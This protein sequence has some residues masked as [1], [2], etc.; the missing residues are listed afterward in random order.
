MLYKYFPSGTVKENPT[1]EELVN[2]IKPWDRE[3]LLTKH[4]VAQKSSQSEDLIFSVFD[5]NLENILIERLIE[6]LSKWQSLFEA[7][8][9]LSLSLLLV[10]KFSIDGVL[11]ATIA[12]YVLTGFWFIP[13][14]IF[15]NVFHKSAKSYFINYGINVLIMVIVLYL[16]D[17]FCSYVG[18]YEDTIS[19]MR[20][21]IETTIFTLLVSI[22]Y[23]VIYY[24]CYKHFRLLVKRLVTILK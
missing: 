2:S 3:F 23:F 20:W 17:V 15:K 9:N 4:I 8:I 19:T 1:D 10:G 6:R 11:F 12:S 22:V 5:V 18:F 7:I 14:Y 16:G 21:F 24:C 13:N